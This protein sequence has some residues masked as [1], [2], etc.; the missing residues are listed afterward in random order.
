M[1][2]ERGGLCKVVLCFIVLE[3]DC[4]LYRPLGKTV[5][6]RGTLIEV[7]RGGS[8]RNTAD[9]WLVPSLKEAKKN[10]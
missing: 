8:R 10:N 7:L 4:A 3:T 6:R 1:N 5:F 2:D 9:Q